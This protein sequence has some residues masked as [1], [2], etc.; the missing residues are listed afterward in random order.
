[1]PIRQGK[2]CQRTALAGHEAIRSS[3]AANGCNEEFVG[4]RRDRGSA[5]LLTVA[6][7]LDM[8]KPIAPR[9]AGGASMHTGA[10]GRRFFSVALMS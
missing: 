3:A 7:P 4:L 9:D 6:A 1:M 2:Y 10:T 5:Q 8:D